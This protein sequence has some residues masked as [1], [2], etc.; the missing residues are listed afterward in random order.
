M[1]RVG[2][3]PNGYECRLK[4]EDFGER[5]LPRGD[6]HGLRWPNRCKTSEETS[7]L[8]V[9]ESSLPLLDKGQVFCEQEMHIKGVTTMLG[10]CAT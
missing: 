3:Q 6:C 10:Q 7:G 8:Q 1:V 5:D 4:M 2:W 9:R